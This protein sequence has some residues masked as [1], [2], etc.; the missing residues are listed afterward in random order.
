MKRLLSYFGYLSTKNNVIVLII[1]IVAAFLRLYRIQDYMTFLGDEGRDVLVAYNI[2][3]GHLTL[4]G[5][6]PR[7][8]VVEETGEI[9]RQ[10]PVQ[11]AAD[12][13]GDQAD[14]RHNF[15]PSREFWSFE[16]ARFGSSQGQRERRSYRGAFRR[17]GVGVQTG[18][19]IN[20][21]NGQVRCIDSFNQ[22]A[23]GGVEGAS[24]PMP[25]RP[26]MIQRGSFP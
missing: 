20:G 14:V 7:L 23:P 3:H 11:V 21:Q 1:L 6:S 5:Y 24:S 18:G 10:S 26:S 16:Q 2:L 9:F 13:A 12:R 22:A 25:K 17:P 15:Q 19:D 8:A 4:L